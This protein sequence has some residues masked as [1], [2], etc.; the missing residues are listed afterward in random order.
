M[1]YLGIGK[2]KRMVMNRLAIPLTAVLENDKTLLNC[3]ISTPS[4]DKHTHSSLIGETTYDED[5]DL[6]NWTAVTSIVDYSIEWFCGGRFVRAMQ[7]KRTS[8]KFGVAYET[9]AVLPDPKEGKILL[10][11]VTIH[12]NVKSRKMMH[13]DR[14]YKFI[15]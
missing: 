15:S 14:I 2:M 12:P 7:M 9:R 1:Q 6:G 11:N 3:W 5:S 4:G 8:E 13:V 10:Y